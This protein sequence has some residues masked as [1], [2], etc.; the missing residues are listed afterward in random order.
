ME[1]KASKAEV[2]QQWQSVGKYTEEK[3]EIRMKMKEESL[4]E[5][6]SNSKPTLQVM[7]ILK[8]QKD[9][10]QKSHWRTSQA[11]RRLQI[12]ILKIK[13]Q[14]HKSDSTQWRQTEATPKLRSERLKTE[15]RPSAEQEKMLYL[16]LQHRISQGHLEDQERV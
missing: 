1:W 16:C 11:Q 10:L 15:K 5:L 14:G 8:R 6:W 3:K 9:C 4:Y 7:L 13:D 2:A 12:F